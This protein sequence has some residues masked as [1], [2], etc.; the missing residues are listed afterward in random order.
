MFGMKNHFDISD[1]IEIRE[2]DK[3]GVTCIY[4]TDIFKMCIKKFDAE[5]Y[6]F[7]KLTGFLT[8]SDDYT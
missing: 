5:K 7:V 3:A 4:V 2:V 6:F 1:S 8:F